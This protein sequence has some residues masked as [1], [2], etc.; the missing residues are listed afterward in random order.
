MKPLF[1]RRG[2]QPNR[3]RR[4]SIDLTAHLESE[5]PTVRFT[6]SIRADWQCSN[7]E[8]RH[9]RSRTDA[10][11]RSIVREHVSSIVVTQAPD[12]LAAGADAVLINT[13]EPITRKEHPCLD[14]R[15]NDVRLT[16]D[17]DAHA[18][19][20][21]YDE[22]RRRIWERSEALREQ[23]KALQAVL[24]HRGT[25]LAW[26]LRYHPQLVINPQSADSDPTRVVAL[27]DRIANE[28][29]QLAEDTV[30]E[31]L[32]DL[33]RKFIAPLDDPAQRELV[34]RMLPPF[35]NHYGRNKL[36]REAEALASQNP[37]HNPARPAEDVRHDRTAPAADQ[38]DLSPDQNSM[39]TRLPG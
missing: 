5:V 22:A 2:R 17:N 19:L 29:Q 15:V 25:G 23:T 38:L 21:D 36:A 12:D 13:Q 10:L 28:S 30:V 16:L 39:R 9:E 34:L 14:I 35:F 6:T 37:D 31:P 4:T 26:L 20:A 18:A 27:L 1:S 3:R 8:H 32:V 11:V 24:K 33:F 7:T